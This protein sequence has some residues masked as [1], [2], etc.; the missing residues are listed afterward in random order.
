M[1]TKIRNEKKK[2]NKFA[3]SFPSFDENI[4]FWRKKKKTVVKET[5][6]KIQ[7]GINRNL[8]FNSKQK[9]KSSSSTF[10]EKKEKKNT[11][12]FLLLGFVL[13]V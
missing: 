7:A 10:P 12:I 5:L 9:K 2:Q 6:M 4:C 1:A 13:T 8:A 11:K 3:H